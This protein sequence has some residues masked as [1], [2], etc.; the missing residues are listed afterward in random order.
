M[1]LPSRHRIRNTIPGGL[2][3][4]T[5]YPRSQRLTTIFNVYEY[6]GK[7]L[8]FLWNPNFSA[9]FKPTISDVPC[10][11]AALTTAPG[12]P[13]HHRFYFL[14]LNYV[15]NIM[16]HNI[17]LRASY[18]KF[19]NTRILTCLMR[20]KTHHYIIPFVRP[21]HYKPR[22]ESYCWSSTDQLSW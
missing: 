21:L 14:F 9:G 19:K 8:L 2:R 22:M 7:K 10:G 18:L 4:S 16:L 1:T 5:P 6:A 20:L 12:P 3:P 15:I 11:Q 13:P 17:I